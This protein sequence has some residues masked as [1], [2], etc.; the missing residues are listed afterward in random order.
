MQG[1]RAAAPLATRASAAATALAMARL[2]PLLAR[3]GN[4]DVAATLDLHAL[5]ALA[6]HADL[7]RL[8]A[9]EPARPAP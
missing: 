7:E 1:V 2:A 5:A 8:A 6:P 3:A 4:G 9:D